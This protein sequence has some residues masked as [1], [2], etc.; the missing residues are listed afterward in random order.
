[1]SS[2][3]DGKKFPARIGVG[4]W[5]K[6]HLAPATVV[7]SLRD[8]FGRLLPM[9]VPKAADIGR[10]VVYFRAGRAP[11]IGVITSIIN[12]RVFVRLSGKPYSLAVSPADL[13]FSS[14]HAQPIDGM[15]L[16]HRSPPMHDRTSGYPI[17]PS[18]L[19]GG[20][21]GGCRISFACP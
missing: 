19:L 4:P 20:G 12:R 9:I 21:G 10:C 18:N 7:S 6:L 11:A 8:Y 13:K 5:H 1:M 15:C 3:S 2:D 14:R 17:N 16:R